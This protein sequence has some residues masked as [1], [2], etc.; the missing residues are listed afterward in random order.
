MTGNY[1]QLTK[2]SE[3]LHE[4]IRR[5][6]ILVAHNGIH[7]EEQTLIN[8]LNITLARQAFGRKVLSLLL[9]YSKEI[10]VTAA[11]IAKKTQCK[12]NILLKV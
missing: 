4:N 10:G 6:Q 9:H 3:K 5:I 2:M 8:N 7:C 12:T 1:H 11:K